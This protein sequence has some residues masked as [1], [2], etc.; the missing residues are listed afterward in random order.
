MVLSTLI[1]SPVQAQQKEFK[2]AFATYIGFE[3]LRWM[4]QSGVLKKWADKYGI[5]IDVMIAND[6]VGG[7]TQFTAGEIDAFATTSLD[8]LTMP[9]AGG[10]ET[11][12]FL[13]TDFSDG[14]D[15][16]ISKTAKTMK[17][18]A[19]GTVWVMQFTISHYVLQRALAMNGMPPNAVTT[20]NLSD[21]DQAA[22]YVA[23]P[24]IEHI[25]TY[26]P[27]SGPMMAGVPSS[28]EIFDSSSI[29]QEVMDLMIAR[30]ET[31]KAS[32]EFAKALTGAWYETMEALKDPA[33]APEVKAFMASALQTDIAGLEDQLSTTQF[34]TPA[35][36]YTSLTEK[37]LTETFTYIRDFAFEN[38]LFGQSA[39]TLDDIV[40]TRFADGTVLGDD[41]NVMLHIDPTFTKMAMDGAL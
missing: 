21:A 3:P 2:V 26:K 32:P 25:V 22:A 30:T 31:L 29:P 40:G 6:Y 14:N 36:A 34:L 35:E 24:E 23:R 17:D 39:R 33:R 28:T 13:I 1:A 37:K 27:A 8:A 19:G 16:I 20:T 5:T 10:T 18:L 9:A 4:H 7:M 41:A 15:Q 11:S 12:I 38:G